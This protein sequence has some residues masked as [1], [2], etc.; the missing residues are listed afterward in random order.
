ML[1]PIESTFVARSLL[2]PFSFL[3][4]LI[5]PS[6][7]SLPHPPQEQ[8]KVLP[9]SMLSPVEST[10]EE[11]QLQFSTA[12]A[13]ALPALGHPMFYEML[14]RIPS[15]SHRGRRRMLLTI[16]PWLKPISLVCFPPPGLGLPDVEMVLYWL[17][18]LCT[19]FALV[20]YWFCTGFVLVL[21]RDI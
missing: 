18:W 1:G 4:L 12:L 21:Y 5:L 20:L 11:N 10:F 8:W 2:S 16:L 19:G 14:K 6:P 13:Q 7:F 9:Y 17:Y 15:V 3:P